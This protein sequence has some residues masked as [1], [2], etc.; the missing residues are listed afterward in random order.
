M[1]RGGRSLC[2]VMGGCLV[3]AFQLTTGPHVRGGKGPA[4]LYSSCSKTQDDRQRCPGENK[5][6]LQHVGLH[7]TWRYSNK[8]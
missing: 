7:A 4:S 2:L 6:C 3:K 1:V 5:T 8:G